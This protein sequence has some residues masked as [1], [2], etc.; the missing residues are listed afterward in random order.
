LASGSFGSWLRFSGYDFVIVE[1]KA[2]KPT[3]VYVKDGQIAF[4]KADDLWGLDT[5]ETRK[6][7]AAKVGAQASVLCIGPAGE[8]LVRYACIIMD[9][10]EAGRGG[11]GAVLGSKNLKAIVVD[12][13]KELTTTKVLKNLSGLQ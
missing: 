1:G 2:A 7:I 4:Q 9:R 3:W 13:Q 5:M 10:R 8:N 12:P 6:K 11:A